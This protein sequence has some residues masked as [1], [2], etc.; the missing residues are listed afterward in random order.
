MADEACVAVFGGVFVHVDGVDE[1]S[2]VSFVDDCGD[3]GHAFGVVGVAEAMP[4][5]DGEGGRCF[6]LLEREFLL[7]GDCE[8]EREE[9]QEDT[10]EHGRLRSSHKPSADELT[11][12]GDRGPSAS[13]FVLP[14]F[15]PL[16]SSTINRNMNSSD[17]ITRPNG[18]ESLSTLWLWGKSFLRNGETLKAEA[19]LSRVNILFLFTLPLTPRQSPNSRHQRMNSCL[20][21][22]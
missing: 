18:Q 13:V 17:A 9:T 22:G 20:R 1:C 8:G 15:S 3:G 19:Y 10:K 5:D 4:Q 14:V 2:G 16:S 7:L 21:R 11:I 12:V 6:G